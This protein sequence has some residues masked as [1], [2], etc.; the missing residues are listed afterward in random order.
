VITPDSRAADRLRRRWTAALGA[1]LLCAAAAGCGSAGAPQ[2]PAAQAQPPKTPG[3]A[4]SAPAGNGS[5]API[6]I[7]LFAP[8]T[9]LVAGSGHDMINAWNLWWNHHPATIDGHPVKTFIYDTAGNPATA[10]TKTRQAVEQDHIQMA[11]GPILANVTIAM[12]N[13]LEPRKIPLFSPIGSSDDLT[14]QNANPYFVRV[15]GWTSSQTTHPAGVWAYQQGYRRVATIC[16]NYAFG[17]QSAGGFAQTFTQA[18]GR[19]VKQFWPPLGTTDYQPYLSQLQAVH[20]DA[21]F[22]EMAGADALHFLEQW[23]S[24]GL[25][26]KFPIIGQETLTDQANSLRALKPASD[27]LGIVTFGHFAEGRDDPA[28]KRFVAAYEEKYGNLPSYYGAGVY[29]TAQWLDQ[30]LQQVHG[31]VSDMGAFLAAVRAVKLSDSAFGPM[32]LDKYGNP[33]ENVYVRKVVPTPASQRKYGADWNVVLHT[34][35]NVSQFW[36]YPPDQYL[37][38]PQYTLKFQGFKQ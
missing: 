1:L 14:Q 4:A 12:T 21:V 19:I 23:N 11:V 34:Y 36:N 15:A 5:A 17:W 38:Q 37:K 27:A 2:Q 28:T 32:S 7:G 10:L 31:D 18:G 20:P 9:G 25:M 8:T 13:Y 33:I 26:G 6:R 30:A 24:F 3:Q 35:P 29:V 22:V 16:D